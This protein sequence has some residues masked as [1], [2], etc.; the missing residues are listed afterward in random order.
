MNDKLDKNAVKMQYN[1]EILEHII[2][3]TNGGGG[4]NAWISYYNSKRNPLKKTA[5]GGIN[6][7]KHREREKFSQYG[8]SMY[9]TD[10]VEL[11]SKRIYDVINENSSKVQEAKKTINL[12]LQ[13][14]NRDIDICEI[15]MQDLARILLQNK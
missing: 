14:L 4:I 11:F 10:E 8:F 13:L 15:D 9:S 5:D 3:I 6:L 1:P 2:Q 7:K 12:I